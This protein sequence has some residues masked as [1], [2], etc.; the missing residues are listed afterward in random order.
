MTGGPINPSS[1]AM[2]KEER[3]RGGV[4]GGGN[5]AP[6]GSCPLWRDPWPLRMTK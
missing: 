2:R 1:P 3:S 6:S 4:N 5:G